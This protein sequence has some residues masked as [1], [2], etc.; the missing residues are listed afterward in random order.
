MLLAGM[1][2]AGQ[3][4]L[5]AAGALIVGCGALGSV[6]A[7]MLA[8]AGVGRLRVVDRDLVEIT[9]LQRQ[10]LFDESDVEGAVPKAVAAA[11]RL[12][13]INSAVRIE[14]MVADMSPANALRLAE[15]CDIVIDGT[16][17]FETRFLLNDVAVRCGLP[18]VYGGAVGVTGMVFNVLPHTREGDREWERLGLAGPCLRCIFEEA[19]AA[20]SGATCDTAGVLGPVAGVVANME[21]I[22]AIK[23]LS[24]NVER[25]SRSLMSFDAW[26]NVW[27]SMEVSGAYEAGRCTACGERRFD[28][29]DGRGASR[30]VTLCGRNAVQISGGSAVDLNAV[31]GRLERH[32][33]VHVNEFL[34]RFEVPGGAGPMT[35]TVF[36][37]GRTIV[38]GT[39]DPA[40]AR[41]IH[42]RFIGA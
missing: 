9:N 35:L 14:P 38:H 17:N 1:G 39:A 11:R 27:R 4:R 41:A 29:L 42:A 36:A 18:Y 22:E 26:A 5:A 37:D 32:G 28:Y 30:A 23:Y 2:E 31:A 16:D 34:L 25:M 40:A 7:E 15:G 20:G 21:A 24:G 19:P 3:R 33:A 8:R 13:A 10:V 6:I 12:G